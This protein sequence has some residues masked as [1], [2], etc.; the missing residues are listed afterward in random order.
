ML[1]VDID[2]NRVQNLGTKV[3][4]AQRKRL[5]DAASKG[6]A[7]SQEVVPED[8]GTLRQSS[9][10]PE[11]RGDKLVWGYTSPYARPQEFGTEPFYP[12]LR[13]LLEWSE[14]VSDGQSL[15]WYVARVK[16]PEEGVQASPFVRPGRNVQED[17]LKSNPLGDYLEREL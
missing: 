9:F 2:S 4:K 14:R 12:P 5:K 13:P 7:F 8:R 6:F 10:Q 1:G 17:Y 11:W 15:G 3:K 16:I